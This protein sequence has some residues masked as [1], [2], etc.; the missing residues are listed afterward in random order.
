MKKTPSVPRM[1]RKAILE[2]LEHTP[3]ERVLLGAP[4]AGTLTPKQRAFA[5]AV[6]M[7]DTKA[8][9]YRKAYNTTAG[10]VTVGHTAHRLTTQPKIAAQIEA[11][12]LA[13]EARKY[14]TPAALRSLVVERLTA[15]AIDSDIPPAQRLRALELLGKVTE[16]AAFTERREV[17]TVT[18]SGSLRERLLDT[19]RNAIT[20]DAS[21]MARVRAAAATDA[22]VSDIL[23]GESEQEAQVVGAEGQQQAEGAPEGRKAVADGKRGGGDPTH[24]PPPEVA[25]GMATPTT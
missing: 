21:V 19:L 18:D 5:K 13:A 1:S 11:F 16:V 3:I 12:K 4:S 17:V 25:E 2:T 15:T 14:A 10:P 8:G 7:G 6:A 9:A 22:L 24:P 20:T 23:S